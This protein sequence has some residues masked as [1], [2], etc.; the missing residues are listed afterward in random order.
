MTQT[1]DNILTRLA[2]R[3]VDT[4]S[5]Q[6]IGS[7]VIVNTGFTNDSILIVTA[8]HCLYYDKEK[9]MQPRKNVIICFYSPS[10]RKYE[11]L[12][13][14][15][16]YRLVST[17]SDV[18][19]LQLSGEKTERITGDLPIIQAITERGSIT[20]FVFKGFP[21]ATLGKEIVS[22][23]GTYAQDFEQ[24][25]YFQ[26]TFNEDFT[27]STSAEP[28]VDGF[29]GS[30]I[31]LQ[32]NNVLYLFG[33]FLRFRDSGKTIYG[34]SIKAVNDILK[35]NFIETVPITF[36]NEY[37]LT[38]EVIDL[39]NATSIKNLG[40][41]YN[42][43]LNL[44]SSLSYVFHDMAKDELFKQRF[45]K[46]FEDWFSYYTP[47]LYRNSHKKALVLE[48][49]LDQLKRF[50]RKWLVEMTWDVETPIDIQVV[51]KNIDDF[52]SLIAST[53]KELY[54][55]RNKK[56]SRRSKDET[57][58]KQLGYGE[59]LY[60]KEFYWLRDIFNKLQELT[61]SL[62]R[63]SISLTNSP[64]LIITG[65]QGSGK[66]HLLADASNVVLGQN[67]HSL[68]FLGQLFKKN[69]NVWENIIDLLNVQCSKTELLRSL[70]NFGRYQ[71]SRFLIM[72]DALNEGPGKQLWHDELAGFIDDILS[73]PYLALVLT[74]RTTYSDYLVPESVKVDSRITF[75]NHEG[76]KGN[77]SAAL[78]SFCEYYGLQ[79]PNFPVLTPEYSNPL[80][81]RLLC[82]GLVDS[83]EKYLPKGISGLTKILT[84]YCSA[85][86]RKIS[87]QNEVYRLRT[88][89]VENALRAVARASYCQENNRRFSLDE[90]IKLFD[91]EFP[92]TP[93]LLNDLINENVFIKSLNKDRDSNKDYEG[94]HF[95][96]ERLGDF[97]IA[98]ELLANYISHKEIITA[99]E[100]TSELGSLLKD[101]FWSSEGV[102]EAM[103]VILPEKFELEIFEVYDW[104][105]NKEKKETVWNIDEYLSSLVL[106]SL[107]WRRAD[108]IDNQKITIWL[109][110]DKCKIEHGEW[111]LFLFE[112]CTTIDHPFNGDRL[113][114]NLWQF[115]L[116]DRDCF[117][118][119]HM[120]HYSRSDDRGNT[121]PIRRLLDWS[122]RDNIST[123]TDHETARLAG[124]TLAWLLASVDRKLRDESTKAMINLLQ[125]QPKALIQILKAFE[126][127]NDPYIA[128]RL[129]AVCY[130][131]M[132]RL[133]EKR[134]IQ[135]LAKYVYRS[136]F[137]NKH[138]ILHVLHRDYAK[139]CLEFA[140]HKGVKF[141]NLSSI[142][143]LTFKCAQLESWPSEA[144]IKQ[145]KTAFEESDTELRKNDQRIAGKIHFSVMSWDFGRYTVE[146]AIRM[147]TNR[148]FRIEN[149]Y[150]E[151]KKNLNS[152]SKECLSILED[153][154]EMLCIRNNE[155]NTMKA[156]KYELN[157]ADFIDSIQKIHTAGLNTLKSLITSAEYSKITNVFFPYIKSKCE[158]HKNNRDRLNPEPIKRWIV[159]RAYE[160]GYELKKHGDFDRYLDYYDNSTRRPERIGKKYQWI[161]LHEVIAILS[162]QYFIR[163]E[164]GK[165]SNRLTRFRGPWQNYLRD[166]D[167]GYISKSEDS[168]ELR[169]KIPSWLEVK[170][171]HW[172]Q[173]ALHWINNDQDLP[174]P[175]KIISR[176]DLSGHEWFYLQL[177]CMWK[178]PNSIEE[179]DYNRKSRE[180]WYQIDSYLIRKKEK[181]KVI[182]W[183]RDK[184][185][186]DLNMPETNGVSV[187][188]F[189]REN[190]WSIVSNEDSS[191]RNIWKSLENT[192][193]KVMVTTNQ[194][195]GEMSSDQSG[196]HAQHKMPCK[197]IF[198]GMQLRYASKDGY[199]TDRYGEI[200]AGN[201]H[202][203]HLLIKKGPFLKYL[204]ANEYDIVWTNMGEKQELDHSSHRYT[205]YKVIN[206]VYFLENEGLVGAQRL[207]DRR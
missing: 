169:T 28:K 194:A 15:I 22:G 126:K 190:Y 161:A 14:E 145:Y 8:A 52:T 55:L 57:N 4:E 128:E 51:L 165:A 17:S 18:A 76:F 113:Y 72:I 118:Q 90:A 175:K 86:H 88:G 112:L 75:K 187:G 93:L 195:V 91:S 84:T 92:Q 143:D 65:D 21:S 53:Q 94:L 119:R 89:I 199:F 205:Q 74:V 192:R 40:P 77:E 183:L 102:L 207:S 105:F 79:S 152:P 59:R 2:V 185:F 104:A 125:N 108:S 63:L 188:L 146:S 42:E 20:S 67:Q 200:I 182:N 172:D 3:I 25:E 144:D 166:I 96:Y 27:T 129:Y 151:F 31:Y 115:T 62:N 36:F 198:E 12:K 204:E 120:L 47:S 32:S 35:E 137:K 174:N 13:T 30:G 83:G 43:K 154:L 103:S 85:I 69:K 176:L 117:W 26:L 132:L 97:Y 61:E 73:F 24:E 95:S 101:K 179:E 138:P 173:P 49:K 159:K 162:D 16:D 142:P 34:R 98:D 160:L 123:E 150:K 181:T 111:Y 158:A 19:I 196:A 131:C 153:S 167:P 60:E 130:G 46:C 171:D 127:V 141:Y 203:N 186:F 39:Y 134:D 38:P 109:K 9:Y 197:T 33:V 82:E 157:L 178:E 201:F 189:S 44:R 100:S 5:N 6:P 48:K 106:K 110:S 163:E 133:S 87:Q 202:H 78:H 45:L 147:F 148:S 29:S 177:N 64:V 136:A 71:R 191:E 139:S 156:E 58:E 7:G 66:S 164:F 81:L 121:L 1:N 68:L 168:D 184:N 10:N 37:G 11:N 99:F 23:S 149:E 155:T 56:E 70:D 41:R 180:I 135:L 193:L 122:W 80:F 107:K 114:K 54:Q 116:A 124:L 206:G 140:I 50:I 170:Y